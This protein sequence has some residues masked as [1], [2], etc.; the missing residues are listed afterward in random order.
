M[1]NNKKTI[2]EKKVGIVAIVGFS[3]SIFAWV[4]GIFFGLYGLIPAGIAFTL[5]FVGNK[6]TK[7]HNKIKAFAVSG[8]IISIA[9]ILFDAFYALFVTYTIGT[10]FSTILYVIIAIIVLLTMVLIHELG[11]Y[12]VGRK[13]GFTILEFSIGFGK[14]LWQKTNKR[15]EKISIRLFPLGGFCSF[16]GEGDDEDEQAKT[17]Q[18][19]NKDAV[20]ITLGN[21]DVNKS[22]VEEK[23]ASQQTPETK[24]VLNENLIVG[25]GDSNLENIPADDPRRFNNQLFICIYFFVNI[26]IGGQLRR[27]NNFAKCRTCWRNTGFI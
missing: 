4:I 1:E 16:L 5:S 20:D 2:N 13:L 7:E 22:D 8:L 17:G 26:F 11:H 12:I 19:E 3:V 18:A 15:G 25:G 21:N 9:A 24:K 27:I 23:G 10:V 6:L 14:V